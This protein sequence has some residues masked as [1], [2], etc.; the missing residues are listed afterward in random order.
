MR[1]EISLQKSCTSCRSSRRGGGFNLFLFLTFLFFSERFVCVHTYAE[2][3]AGSEPQ[4]APDILM[5]FLLTMPDPIL[6]AAPL[7]NTSGK[8]LHRDGV[9]AVPLAP[10]P[11][12]H[13]QS[14]AV[15]P[16]LGRELATLRKEAVQR[17]IFLPPTGACKLY[18]IG[19]S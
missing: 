8:L 16:S 6:F 2:A 9:S 13:K 1:T 14:I 10:P 18:G 15:A 19:R 5:R 11:I 7:P 17:S 4:A 12:S 3:H